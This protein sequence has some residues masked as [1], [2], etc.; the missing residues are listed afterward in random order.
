MRQVSLLLRTLLRQ[1]VTFEGVLSLDLS[2]SREFETLLGASFGF[3]LRHG[4]GFYDWLFFL[5]IEKN[6]HSF[7]F[8]LG[9]LFNCSVLFEFLSKLKEKDFTSL[10]EDDRPSAEENVSLELL[11]FF[12]KLLGVFQLKVEVMV[13]RVR[14]ES[15]FLDNDLLLLGLHLF[16]LLLLVVEEFLVFDDATNRGVGFG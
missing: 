10:F 14:S 1:N 2:T 4:L 3:H 12:Q 6:G 7:P 11:S 16:L 9:Q 5:R 15:D 13:I 8:E